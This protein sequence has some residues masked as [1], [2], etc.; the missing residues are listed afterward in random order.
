[1]PV[2]LATNALTTLERVKEQ[3]SGIRPNDPTSDAQLTFLINDASNQIMAAA[4]REFKSSLVGSQARTFQ[5]TR[6]NTWS[7]YIDFGDYD[8]S[9]ITAVTSET[10]PTGGNVVLDVTTLQYQAQPVEKWNG[11]YIGVAV[12]SPSTSLGLPF[13]SG[14]QHTA[15]VTGVWG[16]PSVPPDVESMCV[17][18]VLEWYR[19]G[20]TVTNAVGI[21]GESDQPASGPR[22]T[23]P[24]GVKQGLARYQKLNVA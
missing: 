15:S 17:E 4:Q 16:W 8:A 10:Q 12:F 21:P 23:L 7:G 18:T 19:T 20:Y 5:L 22:H 11:V 13:Q 6:R 14:I 1:M 2:T 9:T 24:W 3:G